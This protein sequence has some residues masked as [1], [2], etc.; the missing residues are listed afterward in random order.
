MHQP[1]LEWK[2]EEMVALAGLDLL[3]EKLVRRRNVRPLSLDLEYRSKR[4]H[5]RAAIRCACC[6]TES[7][8][9]R[10]SQLAREWQATSHPSRNCTLRVRGA[11]YPGDHVPHANELQ[12]RPGKNETIALAQTRDERFLDCS[13]PGA[14]QVLHC[15]MCVAYDRSDRHAVATGDRAILDAPHSIGAG[16]NLRI[17]R[18]ALESR[19]AIADEAECPPPL[20][21]GKITERFRLADL[22]KHLRRNESLTRGNRDEM[23]RKHIERARDR[24]TGF[25]CTCL[26]AITRSSDLDQLERMSRN[27]R[28]PALRTGTMATSSSALQKPRDS[29]WAS[30]LQHAVDRRKIDAKV[31]TRSR[32][33]APKTRGTQSLFDPFPSLAVEGSVMK[34]NRSGPVGTPLENRLIPDLRL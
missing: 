14:A 15:D 7:G 10:S 1:S 27:A 25:D 11:A 2:E 23:L 16:N 12:R 32:H 5:F 26:H 9:D 28:D 13:K 18:I 4:F 8:S 31:E 30:Y 33:D 6:L 29:L 24:I 34:G 3:D 22:V 21:V 19:T 20:I 17:L